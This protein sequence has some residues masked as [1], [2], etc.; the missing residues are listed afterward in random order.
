[1]LNPWITFL[2]AILVPG[3]ISPGNRGSGPPWSA[4]TPSVRI[5]RAAG[6]SRRGRCPFAWIPRGQAS[7]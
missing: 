5:L 6:H 4:K 1:M 2:L 3:G 7:P